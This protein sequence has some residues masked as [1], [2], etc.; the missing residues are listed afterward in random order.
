MFHTHDSIKRL[1]VINASISGE[2][3]P[4]YCPQFTYIYYFINQILHTIYNL[5]FYFFY[6]FSLLLIFTLLLTFIPI[7]QYFLGNEE[8]IKGDSTERDN[9]KNG[10]IQKHSGLGDYQKWSKTNFKVINGILI[11]H[12]I[13]DLKKFLLMNCMIFK[14]VLLILERYELMTCFVLFFTVF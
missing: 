11:L 2:S 10:N 8:H 1:A 12:N 7:Y 4:L 6:Y 5:L 9:E 3:W 13:E 14:L